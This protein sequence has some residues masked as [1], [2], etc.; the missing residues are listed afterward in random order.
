MC[1]AIIYYSITFALNNLGFDIYTNSIIV[2]SCEMFS[3][4]FNSLIITKIKRKTTIMIQLSI[5]V[6]FSLSLIFLETPDKANSNYEMILLFQ[7]A[8]TGILKFCISSAW[9]ICYV[10]V[11]ELF[12]TEVRTI[13]MGSVA[14]VA[15][16]ASVFIPQII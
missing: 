9:S 1:F 6:L 10:Y 2:G 15:Y 7:L 12:P 3:Y 4:I 13:A 5:I 16:L 8:I 11:P 14:F